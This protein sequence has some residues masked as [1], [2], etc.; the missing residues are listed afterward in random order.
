V[1]DEFLGAIKGGL[2]DLK[3]ATEF[4]KDFPKEKDLIIT[5]RPKYLKL[6]ALADLVS[7]VKEIKHPF[8]S[9]KMAK[10]GIDF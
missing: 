1:L 10:E 4:V 2:I 9:G 8:R 7:E 5:G 6:I 3:Q